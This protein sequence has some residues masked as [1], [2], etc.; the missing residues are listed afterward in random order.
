[1]KTIIIRLIGFYLNALALISPKK[2]GKKAFDLFCR[3][4]RVPLKHYQVEFL[5]SAEKFKIPFEG[6]NIQAYK[7]GSGP[8][9]LLLLHG[10]QSHSFRWK[11]LVQTFSHEEYTLYALDAPAHGLSEG[12]FITAVLYN[13]LIVQSI[14]QLGPM[15]GIVSHSLGGFSLMFSLFNK[16]QLAVEKV[17]LMGAPGEVEDFLVS[18][19]ETLHLS[20]RCMKAV[21]GHFENIIG[22]H[23]SHFSSKRFAEKLNI[24]GLL[25]HDEA[26]LEAP[27]HYAQ[28]IN[29]IWKNSQ[30][31]T[32]QGMGHNLRNQEV[33]DW[34][35]DFMGNREVEIVK[36]TSLNKI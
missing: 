6:L 12:K 11:K 29:K 7:W 14:E 33:V 5:D 31:I 19:K 25:I 34:V 13:R 2:S 17:V 10:W 21:Y 27:Y 32:T 35:V 15:H 36:V 24:P 4:Q 3:P 30:L 18:L 16:P 20:E 23:P 22:M 1:M 8:K 9:K 26:D 28:S